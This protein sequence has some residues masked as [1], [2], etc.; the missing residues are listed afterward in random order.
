MKKLLSIFAIAMLSLALAACGDNT[1][2]TTEATEATE[3]T[4][5]TSDSGDTTEAGDFENIADG[6]YFAADDRQTETGET[7]RYWVTAEVKDGELTD[8]T[9]DAYHID[10]GVSKLKGQSKFVGSYNGLY[11]MD[12]YGNEYGKWYVQASRAINYILENQDMDLTF[13]ADG[14]S[15][16]IGGITIHYV[17]LIDLLSEALSNDAVEKGIYNDGYYYVEEGTTML[18]TVVV[19]GRIVLADFNAIN[20]KEYTNADGETEIGLTKDS[21]LENY[22]MTPTNPWY[23]QAQQIEN[24]V[25]EN[26]NLDVVL[27]DDTRTDDI[28]DISIKMPG[29]IGAFDAFIEES[30]DYAQYVDGK[31]FAAAEEFGNGYKYYVILEI[32]DG[33]LVDA[34]LNAYAQDGDKNKCLGETKYD[35][36]LAGNYGMNTDNPWY[37]QADAIT[38][39][40][41]KT[42]KADINYNDDNGHTDEIA[43]VTIHVNEFFELAKKALKAGPVMAPRGAELVDGFYFVT[44]EDTDADK[45]NMG[46]FIVVDNAIVLADL[47]AAH[48]KTVD[49]TDYVTKDAMGAGY[50]MNPDNPWFEQVQKIEQE[51]LDTQASFTLNTTDADGHQDT[52][53]DVSIKVNGQLGIFDLFITEATPT[54]AS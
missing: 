12:K 29:F 41:I 48:P 38:A 43:D 39:Y 45:Y 53:S 27:K 54:P 7:Y 24:Y 31:Y 18:T 5:D 6:Y 9:W 30:S 46:T 40:A 2:E 51:I 17:E 8:L 33:L 35:C 13:D 10:G 49:G 4:T 19:N 22:G 47:N 50:G 34:E 28:S 15:D 44:D 37:E 36:S 1:D 23:V 26:Q 52:L 25:M 21:L 3:A 11:G 20:A 42:Q 32:E 16:E 14:Y